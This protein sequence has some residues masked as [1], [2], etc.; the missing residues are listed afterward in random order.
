MKEG[1]W[2]E[3]EKME[4]GWWEKNETRY[5]IR[6]EDSEQGGSKVSPEPQPCGAAPASQEFPESSRKAQLG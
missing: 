4:E 1:K 3:R 6:G 5:R 2:E